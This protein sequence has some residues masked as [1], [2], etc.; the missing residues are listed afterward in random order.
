MSAARRSFFRIVSV[1]FAAASIT[2]CG[3]DDTNPGTTASNGDPLISGDPVDEI[4]AGSPFSF[5]PVASDPDGSPLT[6]TISNK[7]PWAAF[8]ETTG[9]LSGT[10]GAADVGMYRDITITVSDGTSRVGLAPFAVYV[11]GTAAGSI[12][13]NW[14]P[15]TERSDGS[16]LANLAGYKIYWGTAQDDYA[17]TVTIDTPGVTSYM[18]EQLSPGTYYLVMTA[19]DA[20]GVESGRSSAVATTI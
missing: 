9:Q 20:A 14:L 15:P 18:I 13:L 6:F 17:N 11:V 1:L 12:M 8:S 16:A 5:Q 3:G 7:P 2:A 10:P 19:F 4:K